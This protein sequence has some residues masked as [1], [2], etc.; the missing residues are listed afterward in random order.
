[1][2]GE[3]PIGTEELAELLLGKLVAVVDDT[4]TVAMPVM[5]QLSKH[6]AKPVRFTSARAWLTATKEMDGQWDAVVLDH[7]MPAMTGL[8]AL[9]VTSQPPSPSPLTLHRLPPLFPSVRQACTYV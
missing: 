8:D 9:Q 2:A 4:D 1:M 6:G 3:I 7:H 5:K